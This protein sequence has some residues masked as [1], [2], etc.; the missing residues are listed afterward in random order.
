M[1]NLNKTYQTIYKIYENF[2]EQRAELASLPFTKLEPAILEDCAM[3]FQKEVKNLGAKKLKDPEKI[4]PF[5][6]LQKAVTGF[7]M[8]IPQISELSHPAV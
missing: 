3:K 2:R 8:S 7:Y 1:E 4:S 5:V 6:K